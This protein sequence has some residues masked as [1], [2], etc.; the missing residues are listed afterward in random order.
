[1]KKGKILSALTS[2]AMAGTMVMGAVPFTASAATCPTGLE[3]SSAK[4]EYSVNEIKQGATATVYVD[5]TTELTSADK[6]NIIQ[7]ALKP[8]GGWGTV[9]PVN[10][11][12]NDPCSIKNDQGCY[13]EYA[14]M[15]GNSTTACY[16]TKDHS[17][18]YHSV[19]DY[20]EAAPGGSY[21]DSIKPNAL[22]MSNSTLGYLQSGGEGDHLATF[23]IDFPTDLEEGTYT[24]D[25]VDCQV[26]VNTS[27]VPGENDLVPMTDTGSI[28]FTIGD[29]IT[30][31][32]STAATTVTTKTTNTVASK[33]YDGDCVVSAPKKVSTSDDGKAYVPV[34]LDTN[35]ETI[36]GF[37][38]GVLYDH[39]ALT[40][41]NVLHP[42]R[43]GYAGIGL[44]GTA[45]KANAAEDTVIFP[46]QSGPISVDGSLPTC[47][48]V[49]D[50]AE[51]AANGEYDIE[52][53]NDAS[54]DN[55]KPIEVVHTT[56]NSSW[57]LPTVQQGSV[58][59]GD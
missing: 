20:N 49:F 9:D 14:E 45:M 23:E 29:G 6:V 25:L 52:L 1:M 18:V 30:T 48:L 47:V 17:D 13:F 39:D 5:I 26:F 31:T 56:D 55:S 54:M 35:G 37:G 3:L 33:N 44:T 40:L 8:Q 27:G 24:I 50:V 32:A 58:L 2:L 53:V 34:Y 12:F 51:G 22:L 19:V 41:S 21:T 46:Y 57:L 28:T 36:E 42:K 7:F 43:A 10:L 4:T 15:E 59:V 16:W 11:K 38:F